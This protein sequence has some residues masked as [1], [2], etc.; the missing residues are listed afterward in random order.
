MRT[1]I[2]G[3]WVGARL[4][5][6]EQLSI[7]SFLRNGHSFHLYLY[8]DAEGV[9]A[10]TTVKD[11]NKILPRSRIFTY[12]DYPSYAAFANL[13]RYKLL[14]KKGGWWVDVDTVCIRPFDFESKYVFASELHQDGSVR[15]TNSILKAPRGSE[16]MAYA[17]RQ[18]EQADI[19]TLKWGQTGPLLLQEAVERYSLEQYVQPP[20]TFCPVNYFEWERIIDPST[21]P[22][23]P[24]GTRA[25]H[26]WNEMW[27][28]SGRDKDIQYE[29]NCLYEQLK[30][31][32]LQPD[33]EAEARGSGSRFRFLFEGIKKK[34]RRT[35]VP[36]LELQRKVKEVVQATS[37]C[38]K[39]IPG[40][41]ALILTKN[42]AGRL[43]ACL[44]S[45]AEAHLADEIVVC[46][47]STTSDN[48][49]EIAQR[50]TSEVH[51]LDTGGFIE[52]VL[53]NMSSLCRHEWILRLDDDE[54]LNGDWSREI[55]EPL[56]KTRITHFWIPRRWLIP[57][58]EFIA[59]E[60]WFPDL[61][62]R[63]FRNDFHLIEWPKE[64]HQMTR[65]E[66]QGATL[67][68][69]Y[70]DH[71]VL[72]L[73]GRHEREKKCREYQRLR[74]ERHLSHY[75]LYEDY[76]PPLL[77]ADQ[78]GFAS[79]IATLPHCGMPWTVGPALRYE[80][81]KEILFGS[82]G[83]GSRYAIAGFGLPEPWG[84]W[85]DGEWAVLRMALKDMLSGPA[86]LVVAASAYVRPGHPALRV[87]V[88]CAG[89]MLSE[90][91][92][93]D[94]DAVVRKV[95][96]PA[97]VVAGRQQLVFE[98]QIV[99]PAAPSDHGDGDDRRQLGL[100]FHM[101]RIEKEACGAQSPAET[102]ASAAAGDD[103]DAIM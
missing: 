99:N 78:K 44:R 17:C 16:I 39:R 56:L 86:V 54:C 5:T 6:M 74:P 52:S 58:G 53:P 46:V 84:V 9:P 19:R 79:A 63:L 42:S 40:I 65:V 71:H 97:S 20:H 62:V 8:E 18:C 89:R 94:P 88:F 43:E 41:S 36:K 61:Q 15:A 11:A 87:R 93:E 64:I 23:F 29:P 92:I 14:L 22:E 67:M 2:Q 32:Y 24:K 73:A 95:S 103:N 90:W 34:S 7:K 55:L 59:A 37:A 80:T 68:D 60:P 91:L 27:R 3:L 30:Q 57:G 66:G 98:F 51:L 76:N 77:P 100:C 81:G 47:D 26:L 13:F 75:Y 33:E 49:L 45:I 102:A 69:R 82:D 28:R 21:D 31:C 70:I 48:T 10:G 38:E 12:P 50:F 1:V 101:M 4:S 83:T 96:I 35:E 85:T 72:A 25:V